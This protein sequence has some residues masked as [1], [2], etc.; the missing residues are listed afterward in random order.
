MIL[1]FSSTGNSEY[2]ANRIGKATNDEV[3]NLFEKIR[4]LDFSAVSSSL[5]WVIVAP[6]YAWRIPRIL[7]EWLEKTDLTG[8]RAV[9]FIMTCGG[10]IGN[11]EKYLKKLS[12]AKNLEYRGCCSIVMP[13]NY[14]ALF[15]TPERESALE[16]IQRAETEIDMAAGIIESGRSFSPTAPTFGDKISSGMVNAMFYSMCVRTKKFYTTDAC[17]SCGKCVRVCPLKNIRIEN[18][19]PIWGNTCTHC[20]ACICRCPTE[21]IEYG[22]HSINL[23]RYTFPKT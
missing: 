10:K 8:N 2:V 15:P 23:P 5:P 9:Y 20:M 17:I 16:I 14:I 21:S 12:S 6:T 22:K 11:A 7:N 4:S 3:V 1:Y 18:G 19:K 13:E